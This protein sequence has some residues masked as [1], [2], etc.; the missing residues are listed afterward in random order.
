MKRAIFAVSPLP[1]LR[2]ICAMRVLLTGPM[3]L[4][5]AALATGAALFVVLLTFDGWMRHGTDIFLSAVQ[6]GIA[7]CL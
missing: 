4:L 5:A 3:K 1:V 2:Y 7:W 6:G